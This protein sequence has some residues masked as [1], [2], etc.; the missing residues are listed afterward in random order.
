MLRTYLVL[1]G[2]Q[3]AGEVIRDVS[4]IPLSGPIIGLILLLAALVVRQGSASGSCRGLPA[5]AAA[6]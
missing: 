6:S 1:L 3:A 5:W 4:G 2:C